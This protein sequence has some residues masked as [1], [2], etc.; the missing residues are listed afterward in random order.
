MPF[1][2]VKVVKEKTWVEY[3]SGT[4]YIKANSLEQAE[5]KARRINRAIENAEYDSSEFSDVDFDEGESVLINTNDFA[6]GDE[7]FTLTTKE[8]HKL[9]EDPD[10]IDFTLDKVEEVDDSIDKSKISTLNV[11]ERS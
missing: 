7:E 5:K 10:S 2:K 8:L 4:A 11:P 3:I 1:F 6:E 9:G